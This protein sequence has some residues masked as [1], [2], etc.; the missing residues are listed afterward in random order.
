MLHGGATFSQL[1]IPR[2]AWVLPQSTQRG[3]FFCSRLA[4]PD[5]TA[6]G[7]RDLLGFILSNE[8]LT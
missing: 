4:L 7:L 5:T 2:L 6:W 1:K 8:Y 3:I